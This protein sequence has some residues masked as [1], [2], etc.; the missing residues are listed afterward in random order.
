MTTW[1]VGVRRRYET[2]GAPD[3]TWQHSLVLNNVPSSAHVGHPGHEV[4][5]RLFQS[6]GQDAKQD[7]TE[8]CVAS[9]VDDSILGK[10]AR[11]IAPKTRFLTYMRPENT[12]SQPVPAAILMAAPTLSQASIS[13]PVVTNAF[14]K[15]SALT[16]CPCWSILL[17]ISSL[18]S[19]TSNLC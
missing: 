14:G 1:N 15:A 2:Q 17:R 8:L 13:G 18:V 7:L 5:G 6:H 10:G 11:R 3:S 19:L 9:G 12:T 4:S 16:K